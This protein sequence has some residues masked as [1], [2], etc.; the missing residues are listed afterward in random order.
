M[1]YV[2]NKHIAVNSAFSS[3]STHRAVLIVFTVAAF[4]CLPTYFTHSKKEV[5]FIAI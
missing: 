2:V 5:D 1:L 4:S 3:E